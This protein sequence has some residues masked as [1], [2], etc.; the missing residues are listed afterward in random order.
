[1]DQ[2]L[3]SGVVVQPVNENEQPIITS[4]LTSIFRQL[5]DA[6]DDD[7]PTRQTCQHHHHPKGLSR[8]ATQEQPQRILPRAQEIHIFLKRF[9]NTSSSMIHALDEILADLLGLSSTA[10]GNPLHTA[11]YEGT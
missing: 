2:L 1:M 8:G 5:K 3:D 6:S 4:F 7:P 11:S 9:P 10:K